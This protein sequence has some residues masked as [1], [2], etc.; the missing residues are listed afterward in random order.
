MF[1][2]VFQSLK[3][4]VDLQNSETADN[5]K[6]FEYMYVELETKSVNIKEGTQRPMISHSKHLSFGQAP[7]LNIFVRII[8]KAE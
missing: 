3:H 1:K 2:I 7:I 8:I 5:V 6:I 4:Y